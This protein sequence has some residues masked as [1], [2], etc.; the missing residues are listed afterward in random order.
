MTQQL[1]D[2]LGHDV[3]LGQG[4]MR[5]CLGMMDPLTERFY[6]SLAFAKHGCKD[7]RV[8]IPCVM[9]GPAPGTTNCVAAALAADCYEELDDLLDGGTTVST[10][11]EDKACAPPAYV[12][13][14]VNEATESNSCN[15][16]A[17]LNCAKAVMDAKATIVAILREGGCEMTVPEIEYKMLWICDLQDLIPTQYH[18][19]MCAAW[20]E[21]WTHLWQLRFFCGQLGHGHMV[22]KPARYFR[23]PHHLVCDKCGFVDVNLPHVDPPTPV[24]AVATAFAPGFPQTTPSTRAEYQQ[25]R[26][27]QQLRNAET[28]KV[29]EE[30]LAAAQE[31]AG[32]GLAN[33]A[34]PIGVTYSV[35]ALR[36]SGRLLDGMR[37]DLSG[38]SNTLLTQM[39]QLKKSI[40]D[41][42]LKELQ[43]QRPTNLT[44]HNKANSGGASTSSGPAAPPV[45]PQPQATSP[46]SASPGADEPESPPPVAV[47]QVT[48]AKHVHWAEDSHLPYQVPVNWQ[49][50]G[51]PTYA[52]VVASPAPIRPKPDGKSFKK[53][54]EVAAK[55]AVTAALASLVPAANA[56]PAQL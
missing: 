45:V 39:E 4:Y 43:G 25:S 2:L 26:Q 11:L 38:Q 49:N 22:S 46:T 15:E 8:S 12:K 33:I 50:F 7:C 19:R 24:R 40:K 52:A 20:N 37:L 48:T 10:C 56:T 27:Q 29:A 5:I 30:T 3:I 47:R 53:T 1:V 23:H 36:N 32:H 34:T 54:A 6:Y 21:F 35:S 16:A 41:D 51:R 44:T 28:R 9:S 13:P 17:Y 18:A 31:R 55:A 42:V 14:L